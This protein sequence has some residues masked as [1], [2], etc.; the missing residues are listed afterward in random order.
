MINKSD[1]EKKFSK[2]DT[3]MSTKKKYVASIDTSKQYIVM[4]TSIKGGATVRKKSASFSS[5]FR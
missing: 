5:S 2:N 1:F 4:A 3:L